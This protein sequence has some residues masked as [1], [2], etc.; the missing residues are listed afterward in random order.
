M[1]AAADR[2]RIASEYESGYAIVFDCGL[3]VLTDALGRGAA[4]LKAIVSLHLHLLAIYPDTLIERKA[5]AA[6]AQRVTETAR[7]VLAGDR[8]VEDFDAS[9]RDPDHRLNPGTT[10]DLVAGTLL[11]ALL[12]GV[13]LP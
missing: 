5:G 9:L 12:T 4:T 13:T 10:A 3:P 6:A 8:S 2:D 1:A 7:E 11:A